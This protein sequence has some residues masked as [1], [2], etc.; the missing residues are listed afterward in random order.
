MVVSSVLEAGRF[1]V[2]ALTGWNPFFGI[3]LGNQHVATQGCFL[4]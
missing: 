1:T 3:A 2:I 4:A